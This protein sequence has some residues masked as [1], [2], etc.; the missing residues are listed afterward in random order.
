MFSA[1]KIYSLTGRSIPEFVRERIQRQVSSSSTAE[2]MGKGNNKNTSEDYNRYSL[3][4]QH[5][6][7]IDGAPITVAST[8]IH[9]HVKAETTTNRHVSNHSATPSIK[10][11]NVNINE[12]EP[13]QLQSSH[14]PSG[15]KSKSMQKQVSESQQR[16]FNGFPSQS[17]QREDTV[18]RRRAE[19]WLKF[20][21]QQHKPEKFPKMS[22]DSS[23][24]LETR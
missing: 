5:S 18:V 19:Y 16:D 11:D 24:R 1:L 8:N 15:W 13:G 22:Y 7:Y 4:V 6:T 12:L 14:T 2:K 23:N 10:P 3:P 17:K 9:E 20:M 21:S